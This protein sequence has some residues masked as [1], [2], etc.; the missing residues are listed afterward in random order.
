[1]IISLR[2]T[3]PAKNRVSQNHTF[4]ERNVYETGF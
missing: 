1:M 2:K 4:S 3:F